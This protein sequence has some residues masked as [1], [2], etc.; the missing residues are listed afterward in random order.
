[1]LSMACHMTQD[2]IGHEVTTAVTPVLHV[3]NVH[4]LITLHRLVAEVADALL[5]PPQSLERLPAIEL[6][7]TLVNMTFGQVLR[8]LGGVGIQLGFH[9][10]VPA[11]GSVRGIDKTDRLAFTFRGDAGCE[12]PVSAA[13]AMPVALRDPFPTLA[14]VSAACPSPEQP[15]DQEVQP[16]ESDGGDSVPVV[17]DPPPDDRIQHPNQIP[18]T[19]RLIVLDDVPNLLV[20]PL[21][22]VFRRLDENLVAVQPHGLPEEVEP[23]GD[24][25]HRRE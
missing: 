8:P 17:V 14:R 4:R 12:R 22:R 10:D 7:G 6:Q 9:L 23:L 19:R 16:A 21:L 5:S 3:V 1:M 24:V 20:D 11:D 13:D 18:L 25:R 2:Q 15:P